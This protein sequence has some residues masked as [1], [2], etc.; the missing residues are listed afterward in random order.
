MDNPLYRENQDSALEETNGNNTVESMTMFDRVFKRESFWT[1]YRSFLCAV[2]G[3]LV[4]CFITV[5]FCYL[6]FNLGKKQNDGNVQ[7]SLGASQQEENRISSVI[8]DVNKTKED[9]MVI[10]DMR[11]E[12]INYLTDIKNTSLKELLIV[13][14]SFDATMQLLNDIRQKSEQELSNMIETGKQMSELNTEFRESSNAAHLSMIESRNQMSEFRTEMR[15]N[16]LNETRIIQQWRNESQIQN[17]E[18]RMKSQKDLKSFQKMRYDILKVLAATD[19]CVRNETF[20]M[21]EPTQP[22]EIDYTLRDCLAWKQNGSLTDGV[23]SISPDDTT[24]LDVYCDMTTDGGGWVVFQRRFDG[25]ENFFRGWQAYEDG[26][27]DINGEFWIGNKYIHI[28]TQVPTE[29]RIDLMA[30]DNQKAYAK[31]STFIIGDAESKYTL[32]VDNFSGDAGDGLNYHHGLKF[33]TFDQDNTQRHTTCAARNKGAW[34]YKACSHSSL[35][36]EYLKTNGI[37]DQ[38]MGVNWEKFKGDH[39]SLKSTSM[40]LRRKT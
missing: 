29:L 22:T 13:E 21:T 31:Y 27:G 30:W 38:N 17:Q 37:A 39:Y 23:Y 28:L 25:S 7:S 24:T 35:N 26:F 14:T 6:F 12:L 4:G 34:W 11:K 40:M 9:L 19:M 3:L 32:S 16:N 33:S 1:K 5:G 18:F 10:H 20:N 8:E 15:K 2:G 36:G